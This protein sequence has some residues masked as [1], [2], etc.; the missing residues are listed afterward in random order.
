MLNEKIKNTMNEYAVSLYELAS[1]KRGKKKLSKKDCQPIYFDCEKVFT[2]LK[3]R[4]AVI[5]KSNEENALK[6]ANDN[7]YQSIENI[8][9]RVGKVNGFSIKVCKEEESGLNVK[10]WL[11]SKAIEFFY[12]EKAV[13]HTA[14]LSNARTE[15]SKAKLIL[16]YVK[17]DKES[18]KAKRFEK[19]TDTEKSTPKATAESNY[20]TACES[21]KLF[22]NTADNCTTDDLYRSF[23]AFAKL[24]IYAL[25]KIVKAQ[26][27]KKPYEVAESKKAGNKAKREKA[28]QSKGKGKGK[29]NASEKASEESK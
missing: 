26:A 10:A 21:V 28:K 11:F 24:F 5:I 17:A 29:T 14:Q 22:E 18:K 3:E 27:D 13:D 25:A 23:E 7:I 15:K 19:L 2:A 1:F 16:D 6:V 20:K 9:V 8:I 4:N 12:C